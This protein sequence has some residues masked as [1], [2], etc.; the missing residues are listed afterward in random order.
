MSEVLPYSEGKMNGYG[1]DDEVG[2]M[3]FS[4]RLQDT[5]S[6]FG[7]SQSKRPPKLG[8]IGRAKHVVI[9]DDRIDEVLKGMSDK[10]SPGV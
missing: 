5:N 6:F 4:C 10:P 3:S 7:T 8:Q 1:P 2:Q 9:E